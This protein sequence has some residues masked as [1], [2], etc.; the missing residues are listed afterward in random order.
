M[1]FP[2]SL[3]RWLYTTYILPSGGLYATYHLFRE[4]ETTIDMW[5]TGFDLNDISII[6]Y[7]IDVKIGDLR[8]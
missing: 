7:R 4:P 6:D 2:G 3:N 5:N 1:E 8:F